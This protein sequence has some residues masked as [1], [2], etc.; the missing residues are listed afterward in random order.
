MEKP[1]IHTSGL[2]SMIIVRWPRIRH[3]GIGAQSILGP[4]LTEIIGI[5]NRRSLFYRPLAYSKAPP[6]KGKPKRP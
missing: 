1:L 4:I 3:I 5:S 2:M 6:C